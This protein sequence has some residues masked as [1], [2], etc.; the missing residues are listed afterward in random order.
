MCKGL[1]DYLE[2]K[3]LGYWNEYQKGDIEIQ[4]HGVAYDQ[5]SPFSI[6]EKAVQIF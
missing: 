5:N 4:H 1:P 3:S 6:S 2:R